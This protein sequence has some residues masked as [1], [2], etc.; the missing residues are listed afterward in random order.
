MALGKGGKRIPAARLSYPGKGVAFVTVII[1]RVR[2]MVRYLVGGM[3]PHSVRP[4]PTNDGEAICASSLSMG[5]KRKR[6]ASSSVFTAL[7]LFFS[8]FSFSFSRHSA[9]AFGKEEAHTDRMVGRLYYP[10]TYGWGE[11]D[12]HACGIYLSVLALIRWGASH[13]SCPWQ[14]PAITYTP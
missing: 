1:R 11:M 10:P 14:G 3:L 13:E 8:L 12:G 5:V 7:P 6:S 9:Q 2:W 4:T